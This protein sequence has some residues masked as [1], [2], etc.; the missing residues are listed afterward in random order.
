MS[1]LRDPSASLQPPAPGEPPSVGPGLVRPLA[2]KRDRMFFH[3]DL[4]RSLTLHRTIALGIFALGLLLTVFLVVRLWPN[5]VAHSQVYI[6]PPPHLTDS[7]QRLSADE[8]ANE[9]YFQQQVRSITRPDVLLGA[10]HQLPATSWKRSDEGDQ[11]AAE[12][13]GRILR[14]ARLGASYQISIGARASSR[15]LAAQIANAVAESF[16]EHSHND[17]HAGVTQRVELLRDERD[18]IQKELVADRAE[19]SDLSRLVGSAATGKA[20]AQR[21]DGQIGQAQ[22]ELIRARADSDAAVANLMAISSTDAN[23]VGLLDAQAK[24]LIA[25]DAGLAS[26]NTSLSQR[27]AALIS[28]MANLK[29]DQPLYKQD[30]DELVQINA[31]LDSMMRDVRAR[32][33]TRL[34]INMRSDLERTSAREEELNIQLARLTVASGSPAPR[35][36]RLNDLTSDVARLQNQY[37]AVDDRLRILSTE[38]KAPGTAYISTL[39][40]PPA[41]TSKSVMIVSA[42]LL[43]FGAALFA[44]LGAVAAHNLDPRVYIATDVERV[45]GYSPVALL[46]DFG[47]VSEAVAEELQFRLAKTLDHACQRGT[48]KSCMFTAVAP[49]AGVTTL[50]KRMKTMLEGMGRTVVLVDASNAPDSTTGPA[51]AET[52]KTRPEVLLEKI[53][54]EADERTII[55]TDAAPLLTSVETEYLARFEDSAIVV[56]EAGVTTKAQLRE[57]VQALQRLHVRSVGFVLNRIPLLKADSSFRELVGTVE[58]QLNTQKRLSKRQEGR[59]GG[60]EAAPAASSASRAKETAPVSTAKAADST[61]KQRPPASRQQSREKPPASPSTE[62]ASSSSSSYNTGSRPMRGRGE[63][64]RTRPSVP[65]AGL[66]PARQVEPKKDQE[67]ERTRNAP[68]EVT[69]GSGETD[70]W[71]WE[72]AR[73]VEETPTIDTP[74]MPDLDDDLPYSASARLGSLRN[75]MVGT[76]LKTLHREA[77]MRA[78]EDLDQARYERDAGAVL[79][80][81]SYPVDEPSEASEADRPPARLV[82]QPEF[83]PPRQMIE[84]EREKEPL[85]T[86]PTPVRPDSADDIETL[87]SWRGQYRKKR[88]Q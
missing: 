44:V 13:L 11:A 29:P 38:T 69:E 71:M 17:P 23:S 54:E 25:A 16:I 59:R 49:G 21:Y 73:H 87:P 56:I 46:P 43:I 2:G 67:R 3:I 53:T 77:E 81:E 62:A 14:I 52:I 63:P 48:L 80:D 83:L 40:V 64:S 61:G 31:S 66:E 35:L 51:A 84:V 42:V 68:R 36:Q 60:K 15:F 12:R 20:G 72:T 45:L 85:R 24:Q 82:A 32:A 75:L 8:N 26:L 37:A 22:S 78:P 4:V 88:Y 55:F 70:V 9:I 65:V 1:T 41:H 27:R 57:S 18:R 30:S 58:R 39:A 10:L 28:Q 19:Q 33:A 79:H 7:G 47:E 76:G 34:E 5:Y 74:S 86:V 50:S 6:Q